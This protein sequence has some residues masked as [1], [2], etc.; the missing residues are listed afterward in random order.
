MSF[1]VFLMR[2]AIRAEVRV[3]AASRALSFS[4]RAKPTDCEMANITGAKNLKLVYS[5]KILLS[6]AVVR[7]VK[8]HAFVVPF[9]SKLGGTNFRRLLD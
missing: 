9:P 4:R 3:Y 8:S 2:S 5:K 7:K 6:H 1:S